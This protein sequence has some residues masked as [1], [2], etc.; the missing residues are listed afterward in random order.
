ML[1][2]I[3]QIY[4]YFLK[5][6]YFLIVLLLLLLLWEVHEDMQTSFLHVYFFINNYFTIHRHYMVICVQPYF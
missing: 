3:R 6:N 4:V 5:N 2:H 1:K